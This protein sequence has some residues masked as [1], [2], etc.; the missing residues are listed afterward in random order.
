MNM[1]TFH[2]L[3]VGLFLFSFGLT[4]LAAQQKEGLMKIQIISTGGNIINKD[5]N[6]QLLR[7]S[8]FMN[9]T[10][11]LLTPPQTKMRVINHQ[12]QNFY[13]YYSSNYPGYRLCP[14]KHPGGTRDGKCLNALTINS[15]FADSLNVFDQKLELPICSN[16][17]KMDDQHFF[18]LK[19]QYQG[20][21]INK[22][23][24][25]RSDTLLI[26]YADLYKLNSEILPISSID[27]VFLMYRDQERKKTIA[28]N[29]VQL[30]FLPNADLVEEVG[31]LLESISEPTP[32]VEKRREIERFILSFYGRFDE[33]DL[34]QWLFTHFP[35]L[36]T[37]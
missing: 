31:F 23:L 12:N 14:A 32:L 17:F 36:I 19:M 33:G 25:F 22:K 29:P 28:I 8:S 10:P 13:G 4:D 21:T 35:D 5:T 3:V 1:N 11:L 2:K 9:G 26:E 16:G 18:Y 30:I 7:G 6:T 20:Q 24:A 15:Y 27:S 37:P 34:E